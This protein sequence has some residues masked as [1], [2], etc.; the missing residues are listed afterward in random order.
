MGGAAA[1]IAWAES[2]QHGQPNYAFSQVYTGYCLAFVAN[3]YGASSSWP[4]ESA[5]DLAKASHLHDPTNP[6]AAPVG[7]LIFFGPNS[8]NQGDGH[9]GISLGG[10]KMISANEP[11]SGTG[12]YVV[13]IYP[14]PNIQS[15]A[16]WLNLYKGWAWPP[17]NW[18]PLAAQAVA[19]AAAG[20]SSSP[21][22][23]TIVQPAG[24]GSQIQGTSGSGG[25]QPAGSGT[26]IQGGGSAAGA[27]GGGVP[28]APPSPTPTKVPQP[29]TPTPTA[30]PAPVLYSEQEGHYGANT[31][32][33]P[34]NASGMGVKIGAGAW[35]QVSCKVYAPAIASA[36]PDGYW[37]RI[38]SS[39][40]N[41][42][43]YAAANTFMNGD[44]WN[45]PYTHNTDFNVP[46][47]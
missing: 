47:C 36:N 4:F 24:S 44:P 14:N 40:W 25:V 33:N 18:G 42:V 31:F 6:A 35:V 22:G 11:S 37:Y 38:A 5:W 27:G 15:S 43:Y 41:N 3:A 32:M 9:V 20:G 1:A 8:Y 17:A 21:S 29:P 26:Q 13:E 39:P 28:P 46:N 45:G 23:V 34:Y 10:G 12:P 16:Y 30:P 7:A 19:T 2:F